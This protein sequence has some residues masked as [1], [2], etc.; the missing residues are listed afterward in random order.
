MK[1]LIY[2]L[3]V[4]MPIA[5]VTIQSLEYL[6]VDR[7]ICQWFAGWFSSAGFQITYWYKAIKLYIQR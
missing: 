3:F 2:S 1:R 7:E 6:N 5:I 4:S